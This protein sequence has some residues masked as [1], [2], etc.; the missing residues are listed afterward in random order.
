MAGCKKCVDQVADSYMRRYRTEDVD[1]AAPGAS[2]PTANQALWLLGGFALGCVAT[3]IFVNVSGET[4]FKGL[5]GKTV[6][7]AKKGYST[8]DQAW[9]R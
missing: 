3:V 6:S 4:S 5:A 1:L 8:L 9:G 7:Y 2:L